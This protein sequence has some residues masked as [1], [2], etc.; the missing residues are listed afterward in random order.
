MVEITLPIMLNILQSVSLTVGVIYYIL[1]MRNNQ[2]TRELTLK[3][4]ETALETRQ[5]QLF[6][7]LYNRW[8]DPEFAKIYVAA[9]YKY[10]EDI[11][12]VAKKI[13]EPYNQDIHLP[14]HSLG[15]FFEGIGMLVRKKLINIDYVDELLSY[16]I[17]W[18][19]EKMKTFYERERKLMNN[20]ELYSN[21][22]YLYNEIIKR[23]YKAPPLI[24]ALDI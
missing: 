3:A 10:T 5:A 23:G 14:F 4:Q 16:R 2:R 1:I 13:F 12:E 17:V 20:P 22:E 6:M 24:E 9:R 8:S 19:W 21:T 11:L 18:W 15:Q 7:Q